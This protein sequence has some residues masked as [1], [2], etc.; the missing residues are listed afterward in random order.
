M[1]VENSKGIDIFSCKKC[2]SSL[3]P[4]S[5]PAIWRK[6][7]C[8]CHFSDKNSNLLSDNKDTNKPD[9]N[10]TLMLPIKEDKDVINLGTLMELYG[11]Y[12]MCSRDLYKENS[13]IHI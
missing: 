7:R 9:E 11:N 1:N 8:L 12:E 6:L 3:P 13:P 10:S 4:N 5:D 2:K